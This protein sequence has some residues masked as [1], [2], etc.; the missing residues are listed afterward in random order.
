MINMQ[1]TPI[2]HNSIFLDGI[3]LYLQFKT[4][5][6]IILMGTLILELFFKSF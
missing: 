2:M 5:L 4:I 1:K 3:F 6:S